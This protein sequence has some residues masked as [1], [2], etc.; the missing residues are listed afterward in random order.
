MN[1]NLPNSKRS[2]VGVTTP[3]VITQWVITMSRK[4]PN[5]ADHHNLQYLKAE[6]NTTVNI[7]QTNGVLNFR[8][9]IIH[10]RMGLFIL[11]HR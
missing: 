9:V 1:K 7:S 10:Q 11:F 8:S 3:S 6:N 5:N 4:E 2:V